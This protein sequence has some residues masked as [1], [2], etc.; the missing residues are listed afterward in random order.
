MRKLIAP[1]AA[2][3]G[4]LVVFF[5]DPISGRRRRSRL[6]QRVPAFFR[7]RGREA[8]RLARR[9]G[10]GAYG[11]RQKVTHPTEAP[12]P[13]LNDPTIKSKVE[14]EIFRDADVPKGQINVNVQDG[15]VQL[16]GEVPRPELAEEL[17]AKARSVQGVRDVESLLH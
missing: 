6:G 3:G 13:G 17:V 10:A 5:F 7:H 1:L 8:G 12:K 14:T 4:A 15:V 16:R 2:A 11:L 9:I